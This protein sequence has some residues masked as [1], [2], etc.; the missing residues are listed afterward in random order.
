MNIFGHGLFAG[1]RRYT[2]VLIVMALLIC[3][4]GVSSAARAQGLDRIESLIAAGK[5]TQAL[6]QLQPLLARRP[7]AEDVRF[8]QARALIGLG[9][10][11]Q[12][13]RVLEDLLKESPDRPEI[14]NNLAVIY[15]GQGD[16]DKARTLLES[17]LATRRGYQVS[18]ENLGVIYDHLASLAYGQA[19]SPDETVST[20]ELH[21][22]LLEHLPVQATESNVAPDSTSPSTSMA[23]PPPPPPGSDDQGKAV[24]T[25]VL[26]WARAWEAQQVDRYLGFYD[27]NFV[28]PDGRSRKDWERS[29]RLRLRTPEFIRV[30]VDNISVAVVDE[31][32]AS[33]FLRQHYSSDLLDDTVV[34]NLIVRKAGGQWRIFQENLIR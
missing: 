25:M 23:P 20:P 13:R 1:G 7:V 9:R 10:L 22:T 16:F 24:R 19:L 8:L 5:H 17:A 31:N 14:Y 34:K 27:E 18:Y 30:E 28:P 11:Q 2:G 3:W 32:A 15:A 6:D 26:A 4:M 21:L 29:R 12:A 33:V